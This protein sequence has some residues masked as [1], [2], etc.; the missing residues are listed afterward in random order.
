MWQLGN[1]I[2]SESQTGWQLWKSEIVM[3]TL[4]GIG[5]KLEN[6]STVEVKRVKVE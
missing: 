1:R 4:T 3:W 2:G 6:F 5:K